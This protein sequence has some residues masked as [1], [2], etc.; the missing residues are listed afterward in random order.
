MIVLGD[1]KLP[2][3]S[4]VSDPAGFISK[5]SLML[6]TS[7]IGNELMD[8]WMRQKGLIVANKVQVLV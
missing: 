6:N 1:V 4:P 7:S 5:G 2:H 3:R 8:Q